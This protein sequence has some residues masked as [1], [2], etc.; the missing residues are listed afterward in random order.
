MCIQ[1]RHMPLFDYISFCKY[2]ELGMLG[3]K[4]S[5]IKNIEFSKLPIVANEILKLFINGNTKIT[6]LYI[7][8]EYLSYEYIPA[9]FNYHLIP[10]AE[11]CFSE[12]KF[13]YCDITSANRNILEGL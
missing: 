6:H 10:G 8:S 9:E 13:L 5:D 3:R 11:C 4:I 2:L 12:L 7:S 1:I